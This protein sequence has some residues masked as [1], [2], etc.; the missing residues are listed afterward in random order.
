MNLFE[1]V[2]Y[3]LIVRPE[4]WLLT[5]FANILNKYK[6]NKKGNAIAEVGYVY[7]FADYRSDYSSITDIEDRK[8]KI[9]SEVYAK[10]GGSIKVDKVT[11]LAVEF[12]KERQKTLSILLQQDAKAAINKVRA[13]FRTVDLMVMDNNGKPIHDISKL[14]QTIE[15]STTL[16]AKMQELEEMI[17][18]E[19]QSTSRAKGVEELALFE[20]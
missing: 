9:L 10:E 4:V 13:Y 17:K 16:V 6:G 14:T 12:Y 2:N 5:P 3:E 8:I 7:Y 19:Q 18:K 15:R 11:D 1:I 20:E